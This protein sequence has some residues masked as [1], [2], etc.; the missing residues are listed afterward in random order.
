MKT[1]TKTLILGLVMVGG[2]AFAA[3]SDPDVKARQML[4]GANGAA[5]KTLGGMA[6]GEIAFD[7]AA[8]EAAKAALIADAADTPAKFKT[9]AAD[10]ASK[11]KPDVWTNW[12]DFVIKA[13]GLGT[14]AAALD[15]TSLDGLKAGLGAV[16]GACGACHQVYKA[17]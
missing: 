15:V 6:K 9:N 7:A 2:I 17:S 8:A 3:A 14:A 10:P 5:M 16:G 4:M 13:N 11:A 12:D 1:F